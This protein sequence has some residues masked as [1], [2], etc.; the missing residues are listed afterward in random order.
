MYRCSRIGADT[1]DQPADAAKSAVSRTVSIKIPSTS[2]E[3]GASLASRS[4]M[5]GNPTVS[6][7]PLRNT[8]IVSRLAC[9]LVISLFVTALP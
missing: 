7:R 8:A 2:A 4:C 1:G 3:T 9:D 6:Y 5:N